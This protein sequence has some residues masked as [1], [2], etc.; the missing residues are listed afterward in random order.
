VWAVFVCPTGDL[1]ASRA[2]VSYYGKGFGVRVMA[3]VQAV[4]RRLVTA[5]VCVIHCGM[6]TLSAPRARRA[7]AAWI[8]PGVP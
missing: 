3:C 7:V 2:L 4:A 6:V 5:H 1:S 8:A